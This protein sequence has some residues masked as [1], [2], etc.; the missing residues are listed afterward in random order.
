[1]QEQQPERAPGRRITDN[2]DAA[3]ILRDIHGKVTKLEQML[4]EQSTAFVL[5]DLKKPDYDGHRK[6][7]LILIK[8]AEVMDSY[9]QDATKR[10]I[11]ILITFLAGLLASG[12][13]MQVVEKMK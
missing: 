1:M 5:N 12:F 13:V 2:E 10:I 6:A 9:K 3:A 11:G 7:H 8:S 4:A